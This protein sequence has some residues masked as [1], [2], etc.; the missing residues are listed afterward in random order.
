MRLKIATPNSGLPD[1]DDQTWKKTLEPPLAGNLIGMPSL[2]G[3]KTRL[4]QNQTYFALWWA[5]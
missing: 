1:L 4:G 2:V 3:G 5:L